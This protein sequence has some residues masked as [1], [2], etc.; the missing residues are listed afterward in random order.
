MYLY[1]WST[2]NHMRQGQ[3]LGNS[4]ESKNSNEPNENKPSSLNNSINSITKMCQTPSHRSITPLL[5]KRI[6]HYAPCALVS[7]NLIN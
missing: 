4:R 6:K 7:I 2:P 1:S 3:T 5:G